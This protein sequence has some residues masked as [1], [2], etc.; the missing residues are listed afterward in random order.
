MRDMTERQFQAACERH[1]FRAVGFM[2]Y[3][4]L[5]PDGTRHVCALNGGRSRRAMLAYLIRESDRA[6][7]PRPESR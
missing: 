3:Y 2:G 4:A 7:A 5:P 1:G 6:A